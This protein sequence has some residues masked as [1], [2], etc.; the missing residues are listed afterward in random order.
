MLPPRA[1]FRCGCYRALHCQPDLQDSSWDSFWFRLALL[2]LSFSANLPEP[3]SL[4]QNVSR[5]AYRHPFS[6]CLTTKRFR[7][8][9]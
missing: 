4:L 1:G 9:V 7:L 6:P 2:P 8:G 5:G 3:C